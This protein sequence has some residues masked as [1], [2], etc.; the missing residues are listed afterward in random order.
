MKLKIIICFLSIILLLGCKQNKIIIS[1]EI[2]H[3]N[4]S[5]LLLM[6]ILPDEVVAIDTVL[7]L[8]GKF[9]HRIKSEQVGVFLLKFSNDIFLPFIAEK[10]DKLIF[11]GDADNLLKTYTIQGNEETKLLLKT[12]RE[13][14]DVYRQTELLSKEFVRHTYNDNFDSIKIIGSIYTVLFEQHKAYLTDFIRSNP[15]KLASLMAFYQT[16]GHN[17]FFSIKEDKKLLEEIYPILSKKYHNSLYI[18]DLKE[19]L[20]KKND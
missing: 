8:N 3:C 12:Q 6:Q 2:E 4:S 7:I 19:K 9:S 5:Y 11:S 10:G 13:L 18:N 16:L 20:E 17:A 1:G 14:D 15:D